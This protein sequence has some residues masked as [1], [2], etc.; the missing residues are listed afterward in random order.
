MT[1]FQASQ[2]VMRRN[3]FEDAGKR[4]NLDW[5]VTWNDLVVLAVLLRG[6]ADVRAPLAIHC[7]AKHAQ[8]IDQ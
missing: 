4:A 1:P 6:H 2:L 8:R 5:I 3:A 7:I